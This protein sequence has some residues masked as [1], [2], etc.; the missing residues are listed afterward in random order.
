MA[1]TVVACTVTPVTEKAP[2]PP[3]RIIVDDAREIT[4][5]SSG[6]EQ[7]PVK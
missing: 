7:R 2:D 1:Y 4:P 5:P 3:T 6:E